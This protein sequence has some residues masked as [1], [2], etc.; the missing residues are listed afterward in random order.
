M[1]TQTHTN[2]FLFRINVT[3]RQ[4]IWGRIHVKRAADAEAL[5]SFPT[6]PLHLCQQASPITLV[7]YPDSHQ[8]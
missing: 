4:Q 1:L 3:Q 7:I 8:L 2:V 6:L 5:L